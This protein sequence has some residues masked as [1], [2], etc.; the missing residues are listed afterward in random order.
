MHSDDA[1][2]LFELQFLPFAVRTSINFA[3]HFTSLIVESQFAKWVI[4]V[5]DH[6]VDGL[7]CREDNA[8]VDFNGR[9]K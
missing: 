8:I 9:V 2:R 7:V 4:E 5:S 1:L 3:Y 6:F